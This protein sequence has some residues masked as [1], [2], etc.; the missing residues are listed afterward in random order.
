MIE[1]ILQPW[2]WWFSGIMVGLTVPLLYWL[3][4]NWFGVSS[5]FQEIGAVCLPQSK[6]SYFSKFDKFANLWVLLFIVGVALGGYIATHFLSAKPIVFPQR[7]ADLGYAPLFFGGLLVGFGAR[8]AN[9]CTSG[10]AITG[11]ANLNWPSLV[12]TLCF[13]IGG[14]TVT[15]GLGSWIFGSAGS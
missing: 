2:P 1:F 3:S 8:C 12:A 14:L 10:H 9:G 4:G 13:F 15:W 6:L 11:L 7:Y 5:S